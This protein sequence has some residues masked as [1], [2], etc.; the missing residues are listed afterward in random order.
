MAQDDYYKVLGVSREASADEIRKAYKRLSRENHPDRKKG[1]KAAAETFKK[2]Q[3]AWSVLGD[4]EKREQYDRYGA[5]FEHARGGPRGQSYTWSTG[6]GGGGP[7]DLE[8]LFGGGID[9]GDLFGGY[10]PGGGGP[11]GGFGGGF[12]TGGQTRTARP[13]RGEDVR[14]TIEI[15]FRLAAEGG[16]FSLDLRRNG[17]VER[18]NVRIPA[19]IEDGKTIR[20]AGEGQPGTRGGSS[21]D[22]LLTVT[23]TPHRYFRRDGRD[24]FLELPVTPSEA[25]LGAKVEAPTLS[26]G[27]LM[28]T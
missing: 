26:E 9:I 23:V 4:P 8:S 10:R 19:G 6:P 2:V 18:L 11:T 17:K 21:G 24:L 16:P 13:R 27:M 28:L 14:Q 7:I 22:L 1:D 5:A 12:G 15:P 3:Q 25:A 20:L